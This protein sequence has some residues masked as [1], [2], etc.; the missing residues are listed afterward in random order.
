MRCL[1]MT[2]IIIIIIIVVIIIGKITR[3]LFYARQLAKCYMAV[4]PATAMW[5]GYYYCSCLKM[6]KWR[7]R[8]ISSLAGDHQAWRCGACTELR[9][10]TECVG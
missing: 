1:I 8:L 2:I 7:Q 9:D 10:H 4:N 3:L 5:D 6:T